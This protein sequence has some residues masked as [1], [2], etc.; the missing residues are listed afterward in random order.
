[1]CDASL[2]L[3]DK[4]WELLFKKYDILNH[5]YREGQYAISARQIKEF[6]EPRL[7]TKFDHSVNLPKI[8]V[9]NGLS[10]LPISKGDYIISHFKAY[11]E[12]EDSSV[13]S[14]SYAS[15]PSYI[16]SLDVNNISSEEIALNCAAASGILA[17]FLDDEELVPTVSDQES[18]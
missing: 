11:H 8:F 7:M 15:L 9:D 14:I 2:N 4:Y 17:D 16:Q 5:I 3:N 18:H 12:L 13:A 6:R 10:I 1:M